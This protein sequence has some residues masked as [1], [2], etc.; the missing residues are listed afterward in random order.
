MDDLVKLSEK[1]E[2][3]PK[4]LEKKKKEWLENLRKILYG[5]SVRKVEPANKEN[6]LPSPSPYQTKKRC[7]RLSSLDEEKAEDHEDSS[8]KP[9]KKSNET[10]LSSASEIERGEK[11]DQVLPVPAPR[12]CTPIVVAVE[13]NTV[14]SIVSNSNDKELM[15]PPLP[16]AIVEN[17]DSSV[18][19]ALNSSGRPQRAAKLRSEKNLKEPELRGKLRQPAIVNVKVKLEEE[20]RLSQMKTSS[21]K[22]DTKADESVIVLPAKKTSTLEINSDSDDEDQARTSVEKERTNTTQKQQTSDGSFEQAQ[23]NARQLR[24]R[25]KREKVSLPNE[26]KVEN[27]A[28]SQATFKGPPL[29]PLPIR[30]KTKADTSCSEEASGS[31]NPAATAKTTTTN[32]AAAGKKDRKKKNAVPHKPIK[33]ERFSDFQNPSPVAS[34]TRKGGS[35]R[36]HHAEDDFADAASNGIPEPDAKVQTSIYEDAVQSPPVSAEEV[37]KTGSAAETISNVNETFNVDRQRGDQCNATITVAS[38]ARDATFQAGFTRDTFVVDSNLNATVTLQKTVQAEA[39][40]NLTFAVTSQN[41]N[42]PEEDAV[43]Q[44]SFE[45]A[46][47]A[48]I[49]RDNS[50]ITEDESSGQPAAQPLPQSKIKP[51]TNYLKSIPTSAKSYKMPPALFNPLVNSPVKMRVE[52]FENAAVAAKAPTSKRVTRLKKENSTPTAGGNGSSITP[53][54]GKL[55]NPALGR[56]L[57]PTQTSNLTPASGAIKKLP[58]SASKATMPLHKAATASSLKSGVITG[59]SKNL[60]RENSSDDVHRASSQSEERKKQREHKHLLAAQQREAKERER[61]ERFAKLAQ[62]REEKLLKKQLEQERKKR[63]MD[64]IN[65]KLRLQ[66][67]ALAAS[68]EANKL[69]AIRAKA[70][71]QEREMLLKLQQEQQMSKQRILPPPPKLQTKYRFEMLHEDDSTDEEGK[72]SY[73][74]PPPPTWSRSHERG[75]YILMQQHVPLD[76]IDSFFSVQPLTADLKT[77][78]PTIDDRYLKRNSSVLWSTPP[79]YSELPKY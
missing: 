56:F 6:G 72:T 43:D 58:S 49:P 46:K 36:N 44:R 60:H 13:S 54:I 47:D 19:V 29:V 11:N 51:T 17:G 34:R 27:G 78:F 35:N 53:T 52:A 10:L 25:V 66:D 2:Y 20:Q 5:D 18:E 40:G 67:E 12:G 23:G 41:K 37:P 39:E 71:A 65:R 38:P 33:V 24:I 79:R 30:I 48:S 76:V 50:L 74:R 9:N 14:S 28:S 45:T 55:G 21:T 26:E 61:A 62:E 68:A 8:A 31:Q 32:T 59:S 73:K 63:E 77:I 7:K 16:P 69:K 1:A 64:E 3:Y 42:K 75:P 57:T 4:E 70:A 22:A 15:P